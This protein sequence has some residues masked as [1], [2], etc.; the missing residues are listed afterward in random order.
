MAELTHDQQ[1]AL[2]LA[3]AWWQRPD[4]H[5]QP[6]RLDGYAGTG[7][8]FVAEHLVDAIGVDPDQV[9]ALAPTGKAARVLARRTGWPTSTIHRA[10]YVPVEDPRVTAAKE[11]L[12]RA[13]SDEPEKVPAARAELA[14]AERRAKLSFSHA[15][16]DLSS[17]R[18]V[19]VDEAPMVG[20]R[21][22]GDLLALGK[23]MMLLGD[24]GQLPPVKGRSGFEHVEPKRT[25]TEIKR[26]DAGSSILEA[27]M[28]V[29]HGEALV[30]GEHDDEAF[31]MVRPRT[32]DDEAYCRYEM[33]LCGTH[34]VR[35]GFN[36]RIRRL[37]GYEDD[38]LPKAG[39]RLVI[40]KN[41]YRHGLFNG[42]TVDVLEDAQRV[43]DMSASVAIRDD[44][45]RELEVCANV[46]RLREHFERG[47]DVHWVRATVEVD[48][49]YALTVHSAQGSEWESVCV[50]DDWPGS[51]QARWLY[52]ALTR[53]SRHVTLV[54]RRY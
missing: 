14:E 6:Y 54:T 22:A 20:E 21:E 28:H 7:K 30:P 29:R 36:R 42:Q 11:R 34:K 46:L 9:L 1:V 49:A 50:V 38:P 24:P 4:R 5:E 33:L 3:R 41:D 12:D 44:T 37:L 48:Y 27:A 39:E 31:R 15:G 26:Q 19:I 16:V 47:V 35:R 2:D 40:R 53:G 8:T 17:Y 13:I 23:P 51:D 43:N 45:G 10:L 32:L 18:L 25:L 52:T